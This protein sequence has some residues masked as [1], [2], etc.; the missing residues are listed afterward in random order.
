MAK[1]PSLELAFGRVLRG[2]RRRASF[3]QETL[4]LECDLD[5][6]YISILERGLHQPSLRTVFKLANV[7]GVP[8]SDLVKGVEKKHPSF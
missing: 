6:S 1:A 2:M 8:P 3:S 4:A 5:R 7:L